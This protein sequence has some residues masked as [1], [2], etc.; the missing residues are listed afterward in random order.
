MEWTLIL[1]TGGILV[2]PKAL[3]ELRFKLMIRSCFADILKAVICSADPASTIRPNFCTRH[4]IVSQIFNQ[5]IIAS[6]RPALA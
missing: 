6:S 3:L 2:Q 4:C 5:G 1:T